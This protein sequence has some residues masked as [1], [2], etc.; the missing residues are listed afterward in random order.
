MIEMKDLL[1]KMEILKEGWSACA[2]LQA[3]LIVSDW[4]ALRRGEGRRAA[5]AS[6]MRFA[7]VALRFDKAR[8]ELGLRREAGRLFGRF[9]LG[10]G[11]ARGLRHGRR[12]LVV[13]VQGRF[14]HLDLVGSGV[15]R[16]GLIRGRGSSGSSLDARTSAEVHDDD[17]LQSKQQS[18]KGTGVALCNAILISVRSIVREG[19]RATGSKLSNPQNRPNGD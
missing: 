19:P 16:L 8:R 13:R 10:F 7:A 12:I 11:V 2:L 3:V 18:L 17:A 5:L 15:E 9:A 6:L 1:A 4:C 14:C